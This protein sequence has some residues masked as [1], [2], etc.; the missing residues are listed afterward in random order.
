[1]AWGPDHWRF[2]IPA[3]Q[4]HYE[5]HASI[6]W[7]LGA[8]PPAGPVAVPSRDQLVSHV[9]ERIGRIDGTVNH[10]GR[11]PRQG[12]LGGQDSAGWCF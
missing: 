7:G 6:S 4:E 3:L 8:A 1:M 2:N 9:R 10:H 11:C 5:V 12:R